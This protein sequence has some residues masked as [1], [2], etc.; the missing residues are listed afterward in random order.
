MLEPVMRKKIIAGNWKMHGSIEEVTQ[1]LTQLAN[2]IDRLPVD[3]ECVVFP[4]AIHIPLTQKL[5]H[6]SP[7]SWGGQNCYPKEAGAYTGE[8]S[9]LMFK[10]YGCRYLLVGHSERR[11]L[12]GEDE[13]K[14][15]E[16]FHHIKEHGIIPVLCV[17]ETLEQREAG[18]TYN[19]LAHQLASI[20][21]SNA[22]CFERCIIAY[23][24]IWAIGTGKTATPVQVQDV[25]AYIR[26]Y[27]DTAEVSI[28]YGGSVNEKNASALFAMPDV[29]GG[30]IGGASLNAQKFVEIVQ[31][32]N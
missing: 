4:P 28:L 25:H 7:I 26:S 30:L 9:V 3:T 15:A 19:I 10:E 22:S 16:K 6:H 23:E 21:E 17:G 32:I 1:L 8:H 12:F 18:Q 5:L 24:P 14:I 29:D 20:A 11:Q 13:K 2:T 27:I 31:C